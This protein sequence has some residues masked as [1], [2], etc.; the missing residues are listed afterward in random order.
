MAAHI[1]GL[2][3]Q[4]IDESIFFRTFPSMQINDGQ[5]RL[6]PSPGSFFVMHDPEQAFQPASLLW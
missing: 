3:E 6:R 5:E 2:S 4:R 1:K